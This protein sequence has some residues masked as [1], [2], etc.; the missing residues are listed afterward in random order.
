M[1]SEDLSQIGDQ[2][3]GDI[4]KQLMIKIYS[5]LIILGVT[6]FT[7]THQAYSQCEAGQLQT[8]TP[9]TVGF[10]ET[11]LVSTLGEVVP[12]APG[13]YGW[14]FDNTNTDGTG[15]LQEPF[16]FP[17]Q[18][19]C[20]VFD[21]NLRGLLEV[22]NL[23]L[24]DG[25]WVIRGV[26]YTE[27]DN[28]MPFASVC[29]TTTD[30]LLVTFDSSI[31]NDCSAGE[32][33][34]TGTEVVP[35]G[36]TFE[37]FATNEV[38]PELYGFTFDNTNTDGTGATE[39]TFTIFVQVPKVTFVND[40]GGIITDSGLELLA[41]TWVIRGE[42]F[43]DPQ[44]NI[45]CSTTAD[46]LVVIF[47]ELNNECISGDLLT[48]GSISLCGPE[49][50]TIEFENSNAPSGG[51]IGYLIENSVTG[52]TGALDTDFLLF[53]VTGM[54]VINAGLSG[55]LAAGNLEDFQG[56]WVF[57]AVTFAGTP[58]LDAI[59]SI[60][61]DSLVITF[62]PELSLSLEN[63]GNTEI[64]P[65]VEGGIPPYNYNWSNGET[66]PTATELVDGLLTLTV[67]DQAMCSIEESID[68]LNT[69]V[70]DIP[71]LESF[72]LNPNP[73]NGRITL[74]FKLTSEQDMVIS[75]RSIDGLITETLINQKT[76]GDIIDIDLSGYT[77]GIYLLHI[78]TNKGQYATRIIKQ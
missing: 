30:S 62:S 21:S 77:P 26:A 75:I 10:G 16:L 28:T 42:A 54:D 3:L 22:N 12:D 25:T 23:P 48:T 51:G 69:S 33:L 29:S 53:D 43:S 58:S 15:A 63:D 47:G 57:K 41:G 68:L 32:L 78:S 17:N 72:S 31:M 9:V 76:S 2:I 14:F 27:F 49:S 44:G 55:G 66:T 45:V 74:D 37:V 73:T 36:E 6:F 70:E 8:T 24:L 19:N 7:F 35:D 59:C 56:T 4:Q 52:G 60:S 1:F 18:E 61:Q 71:D 65:T 11:F 46:S 38:A 5:T 39:E 13:G 40:L 34:T 20:E 50:V 64:I 67:S